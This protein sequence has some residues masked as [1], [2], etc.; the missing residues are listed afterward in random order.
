[1]KNARNAF[2][3]QQT[4]KQRWPNK[5]ASQLIVATEHSTNAIDYDID[6]G[7]TPV[8]FLRVVFSIRAAEAVISPSQQRQSENKATPF[9]VSD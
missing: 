8:T 6:I 4:S 2:D 9:S 5:N 1:M 3:D 7:R